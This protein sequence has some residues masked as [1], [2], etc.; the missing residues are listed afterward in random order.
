MAQSVED[1]LDGLQGLGESVDKIDLYLL[2]I[3]G[4][5][6]NDMKLKVPTNTNNLKNS[7][8]SV[9]ENNTLKF[10][11][12]YYGPFQNY[13]VIGR[14][15]DRGVKQVPFGVNPRPAN[16]IS[17]KFKNVLGPVGGELPFRAR[18]TIRKRGLAPKDFFDI[19][20]I[21]NKIQTEL[22]KRLQIP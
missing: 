18:M 19:N 3:A 14:D 13:G 22:E 10:L 2:E 21:S 6:I 17:Y 20:E 4:G 11:M 5:V 9:V 12:L 1:F 8:K 16:G 15:Q 7:L